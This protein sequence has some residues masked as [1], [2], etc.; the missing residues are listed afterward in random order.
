MLNYPNNYRYVLNG[1]PN[2]SYTKEELK[3]AGTT[4]EYHEVKTIWDKKK[5]KNKTYY[6][7]WWFKKT[8]KEST[9]ELKTNLLEDG[10]DDFIKE[11]E[12][13]LK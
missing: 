1:R 8:K 11:Y 6:K 5:V 13:S 4:E 12:D 10:L 2:V 7:V 3:P 9:W